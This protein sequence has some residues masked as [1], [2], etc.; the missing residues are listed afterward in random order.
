MSERRILLLTG[1]CLDLLS[2]KTAVTLLRYRPHEVVAVLDAEHAGKNLVDLV[3]VGEGI[4]IVASVADSLG[5]NPDH[6]VIGAVFPGGV[7]PATWRGSL[8]DALAGGMHIINGLHTPLGAD[9]ELS[10]AA[11]KQ[12]RVLFDLRHC[13]RE[14][15]VGSARAIH[16]KAKRVLTVGSDCNLGKM[17]TAMELVRALNDLGHKATFIATGQTGVM[18]SGRGEVID[19]IKSDFVSGAVESMV[20]EAD[21]E[22]VEFIVVEGQGALLHPAFSAVTLGLM[23]GCL[24]DAMILCHAPGRGVMRH[25][26]VEIPPLPPLLQ[27]HEAILEPIHPSRFVGLALNSYGMPEDAYVQSRAM[28]GSE[29]G[30]PTTDCVRDSVIPLVDAL[31]EQCG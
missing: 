27:L 7:L 21:E 25:S 30:L 11:V 2:A 14:Y 22:G 24:P 10:A 4:P 29:T 31:L 15:P 16:T 1:G 6:L 26:Q 5:F 13:S 17:L 18:V 28:I 20:L 8:L 23:H 19:A 9:P 12:G 3:G